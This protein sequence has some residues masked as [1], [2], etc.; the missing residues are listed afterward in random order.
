[1]SS[2][3]KLH[4]R[5]PV[6][7]RIALYGTLLVVVVV[8][9]LSLPRAP[10]P[11]T[12]TAWSEVDYEAN[13]DVRRLQ[14]LVRIDTTPHTGREI[15][16]ARYLA[17]ILEGAGLTVEI[18]EHP[19]AKANLWAILEGESEEALVLHNHL[20]V[21]PIRRPE[22]WVVPPFEARLDPPWIIGRGVF[23][24]KSVTVAQLA[25]MLAAKERMDETGRRPRR[26]LIFLA[27]SSEETGS[28]LG[29]RH[30]LATRPELTRRFWAVLTEGGVLE[31]PSAGEI[32]YWGTSFAQKQFLEV[33]ATSASAERLEQLRAALFEA[34]RS[35]PPTALVPEVRT[36]AAAY[37]PS[38]HLPDY[39]AALA[40][41][42]R[43]LS[44]PGLFER[45]PALL[46]ALF[47]NEA[48]PFAVEPSPA[49]GYRLRI[50]LHVLPGL[51]A[52]AAAA[53]LLPDR[54]LDGIDIGIHER[55][56]AVRG[57]PLDHRAYVQLI[58]S[59]L[60]RT[61]VEPDR[62]GPYLLTRYA[63]DARFFRGEGIAAYG[64]TPFR[65]VSADTMTVGGPNE[66]IALPAFVE[67]VE[68]YAQVVGD[69]LDASP[70]PDDPAALAA[71]LPAPDDPVGWLG[72]YVAFDTSNPPGGERLAAEYLAALI[73]RGDPGGEIEV[74][75]LLTPGERANLYARLP[76][77]AVEATG[78]SLVLL[79]HIDVVPA[80]EGWSRPPFGGELH[81]G[82]IW[83][84]GALDAKS[85]GVAH[86]VAMLH[87]LESDRPRRR[88]LVL[89]ASADEEAGGEEGVAWLLDEHPELFS[90]A[91]AVL[92]EAGVNRMT[93]DRLLWW[94][95]ETA[96]K[97][98]LWLRV[99]AAG[100][101]GH[102]S[103]FNP[104]SPTHRLLRALNRV[105]DL[106][107]PW[108]VTAAAHQA[109]RALAG[110]RQGEFAE[111]FDQPL[112]VVQAELDRRIR[113]GTLD[114][115][116]LPG[117]SASFRDTVQITRIDNGAGPVNVAPGEASALIDARL[118]PDTDVDRFRRRVETVL[119]SG[120]HVEELLRSGSSPAS[121]TSSDVYRTLEGVLGVQAPVAPTMIAGATDSRFF[122]RRGVDAYG[123]SPFT[124]S[125]ED[126]GG[127]HAADERIPV[128]G[129]LRGCETMKRVVAA[130]VLVEDDSLPRSPRGGGSGER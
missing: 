26:S 113:D 96:Q 125:A 92:N 86:L 127:I 10:A 34:L 85:L 35:A 58:D 16:A 84:R 52:D 54:L 124:L 71:N 118:L 63:N 114:R 1:M 40:E 61:G 119:G 120:I 106:E 83:G 62:V 55:R 14:A 59:L 22:D 100:R 60:W 50:V 23:D 66:K 29:T 4:E 67:G 8:G 13:E 97:Q 33:T 68:L 80:G 109:Y 79:H 53:E 28:D 6:A 64:F 103:G 38:R 7:S 17:G 82:R 57:S 116:L 47:R 95:I 2:S 78:R 5:H 122:R 105:L 91:E 41:P 77:N 11:V 130:L 12:G 69:L 46:K 128:D 51:D 87:L 45:L 101:G 110:L 75:I 111:V 76:A 27:T 56:G 39:R 94:G 74:R 65:L 3:A 115:I 49:G 88:D 19:D 9:Y 18:E 31:A 121:S 73:G 93:G 89:V 108:R 104:A 126:A 98:V 70:P 99:T 36:F 43:V 102:G 117:M 81:R 90:D 24:M 107:H 37:A 21:D 112:D 25:A 72:R 32:K 20:D 44:E 123:F 42:E 15:D 48:H 129:F 30:I